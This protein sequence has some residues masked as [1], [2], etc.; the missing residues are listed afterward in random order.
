VYDRK[1][2]LWHNVNKEV[3]FLEKIDVLIIGGGPAGLFAATRFINSGL[4]VYLLEATENIGQ[5]LLISGAGQCNYTNIID[6]KDFYSK[7]GEQGK[8]LKPAFY[9]LDNKKTIE[10]FKNMF[11]ILILL[12]KNSIKM[13]F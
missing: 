2:N 5:K 8:F 9:N 4:T 12:L 3:S 6:I 1:N 7:Y 11:L 13:V 10:Y